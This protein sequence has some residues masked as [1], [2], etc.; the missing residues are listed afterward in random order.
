MDANHKPF[1]NALQRALSGE[2]AHAE[3][4][5]IVEGLEWKSVADIPSGFPHSVFELVFHMAFWQNWVIGWL[6]GKEPAVPKHAASSWPKRD[7]PVSA[8]DWKRV[9][10]EFRNGLDELQRRLRELDLLEKGG[11]K[12]R[13]EMLHT[14]ASHNSYHA[15]QV[16]ALRQVLG[17]WPPPSGGLTW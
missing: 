7:K 14:I 13:V 3:T 2:G 4:C 8:A 12:T 15:G 1:R 9:Q 11:N 10:R 16:V 17:Q 6:D 5:N